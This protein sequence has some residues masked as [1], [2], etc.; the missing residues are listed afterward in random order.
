MDSPDM[1]SSRRYPKYSSIEYYLILFWILV[2]F[3]AGYFFF[4]FLNKIHSVLSSPNVLD[5]LLSTNYSHRQLKSTF[6]CF[7]I[8]LIFSL[9][10]RRQALSA[11]SLKSQSVT[12]DF[13]SFTY[14]EKV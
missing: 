5:S 10:K 8:E 12:A 4:P 13:I 2:M 6:R 1:F 3:K 9:L 14:N 7:S 11:Y